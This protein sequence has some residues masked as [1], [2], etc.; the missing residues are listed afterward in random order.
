MYNLEHAGSQI[1]NDTIFRLA[2]ILFIENLAYLTTILLCLS[3][4]R[5]QSKKLRE[6]RKVNLYRIFDKSYI[7]NFPSQ[8]SKAY[9]RLHNKIT[10]SFNFLIAI[11]F[12]LYL[13]KA[14]LA[15]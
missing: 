3:Y 13:I 6:L 14:L 12:I 11:S 15:A 7:S 9:F 5:R 8:T 4:Y 2:I 1:I 10:L